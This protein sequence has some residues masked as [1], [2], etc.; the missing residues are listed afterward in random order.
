MNNIQK[1]I[2]QNKRNY[3]INKRYSLIIKKLQKSIKKIIL[4]NNINNKTQKQKLLNSYY[5][6]IDK[7]TKKKILHKKTAARKKSKITFLL[8][9]K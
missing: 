9:I 2:N 3:K 8:S 1:I 6:I 4:L 7:A 5:S